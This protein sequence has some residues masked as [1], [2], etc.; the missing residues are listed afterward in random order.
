MDKILGKWQL[1]ENRGFDN[2]L[3]FTQTAWLS[4]TVALSCPINVSITRL[5]KSGKNQNHYTQT[6]QSLFYNATENIVLDSQSRDYNKIKK[7]YYLKDDVIHA[8]ITGTIVNWKERIY[9]QDSNLFIR[10]FWLEGCITQTATQE[11]VKS[12]EE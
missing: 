7:S 8:D 5:L 11:F 12:K 3:I 10:Y 4:R 1:K 2:F 9:V 6:I